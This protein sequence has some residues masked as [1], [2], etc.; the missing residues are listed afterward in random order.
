[1]PRAPARRTRSSTPSAS[2]KRC[3]RPS[4]TRPDDPDRCRAWSAGSQV[5]T[6]RGTTGPLPGRAFR[7]HSRHMVVDAQSSKRST[8]AERPAP[9]DVPD[10]DAGAYLEE[11]LEPGAVELPSTGAGEPA[12]QP[13]D[14]EAVELAGPHL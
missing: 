1:M 8:A 2:S 6:G 13:E 3:S 12:E 4:A 11:L 9:V 5:P 10:G 7:G 14:L